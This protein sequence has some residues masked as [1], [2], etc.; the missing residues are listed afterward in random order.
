MTSQITPKSRARQPRFRQKTTR[1]WKQERLFPGDG[2]RVFRNRR[3]RVDLDRR[4]N[5]TPYGGL[6]LAVLLGV[7]LGL[8]RAMDRCCRLLKIH[9]PFT[10]SDHVLT[11]A[12]N[13]FV[14]GSCIQ[15]IENLQHS[16]AVRT[17]LGACR[18]PDP[19]TAGDF[20]RRFGKRDL[21]DLQEGIDEARVRAWKHMPRRFHRVATIDID[22][23]IK[24]VYGECKQ[25]ADFSYNRKWSYHPLLVTMAETGECLRSINRPGNVGSAEGSEKALREVFE[26]VCPRF[27][28]VYLRGD[29][30]FC[31]RTIV[32]LC[33]DPRYRVRFAVIKE[34]SPNLERIADSLPETAWQP[35]SLRSERQPVAKHRK[36]RRKRPRYRRRLAE[37]RRYRDLQ[38]VKQWVT[39]VPYSLTNCQGTFRLVIRRQEIEERDRQGQLWQLLA[40][41]FFLTNIPKE[42]MTPAEIIRF[43][44][45]RCNQENAIEQAK[46]GLHGLRMP[47]GT[48]LANSAYLLAAQIAWCLRAWLSL[49]ALPN[50]TSRWEWKWFRQA[51]VYVSA[52]IV[53]AAK[54]AL[55]RISG[56][57]R[58]NHHLVRAWTRL[59]SLPAP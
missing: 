53:W 58:W 38:T 24:E 35:F 11:H 32:S 16:E 8:A 27:G 51:F 45:G 40:Y 14:G 21:A 6:A 10:E 28:R 34:K 37:K 2:Q 9:L 56:S 41:S 42:E 18:I 33:E 13:L 48:L 44:Y 43:A 17:L 55:V 36:K 46:N 15:D 57:H 22:S 7:K 12:Y 19:T 54:T 59:A 47:T 39:E 3:V 23:T 31:R 52:K 49:L 20:L 1:H 50:D 4:G 26:L 29:S 30:K 25:G 5:T